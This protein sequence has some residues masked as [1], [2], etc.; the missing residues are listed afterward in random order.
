MGKPQ[1]D[2]GILIAPWPIMGAMMAPLSGAMSDKIS[3]DILGIIGLFILSIAL[4][5]LSFHNISSQTLE[6]TLN[7]A[8]CGLGFGLFLSPNQHKIMASVNISI[9][10][11]ASGLLGTARLLGQSI[12]SAV[13]SFFLIS[14]IITG[15]IDALRVSSL[16]SILAC[17]LCYL[18]MKYSR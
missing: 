11:M 7:M 4:F 9:S 5:L 17:F 14:D 12:G 2:I 8:L 18:S 6:I 15:T 1:I 13:F 16:F 3:P 10:G